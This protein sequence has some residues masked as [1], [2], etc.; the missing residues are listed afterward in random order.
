MGR[1]Y[2]ESP[3]KNARYFI[4][5]NHHN[6]YRRERSKRAYCDFDEPEE[7]VTTKISGRPLVNFLDI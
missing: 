4:K 3:F 7:T 5:E 1:L 6:D 2:V